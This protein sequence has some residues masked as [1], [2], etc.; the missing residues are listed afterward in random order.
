MKTIEIVTAHNIIIEYELASMRERAVVFLGDLVA[1]LVIKSVIDLILT[2]VLR[3]FLDV[4]TLNSL[5]FITLIGCFFGYFIGFEIFNN[6]QTLAKRI[7]KIRTV[8]LDGREPSWSDLLG[9]TFLHLIDSIFSLGFIGILMIKT[10]QKCQRLG[11]LAAGT[12]VIRLEPSVSSQLSNIL[13]LETTNQWTPIYPQIRRFRE[14]DMI[15][16]KTVLTRYSRFPNSAHYNLIVDLSEKTA[17]LL[18]I[19]E[20]PMDRIGFLRTLLK[21]Y[22]VLTR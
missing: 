16:I 17:Q 10:T 13:N 11:D 8:R 19:T 20:I 21:D 6:G 2:F 3:T 5:P 14:S 22:I 1:I 15:T 7:A 4:E 9:R 18:E 12:T